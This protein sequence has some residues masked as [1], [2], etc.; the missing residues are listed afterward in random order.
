MS[1]ASK[2]K[3]WNSKP[4][5]LDEE[6]S[7]PE[8]VSYVLSFGLETSITHVLFQYRMS[9]LSYRIIPCFYFISLIAQIMSICIFIPA[10][11]EDTLNSS[12]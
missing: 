12:N 11:P 3:I 5:C 2:H 8:K 6:V 9:S 7:L 1:G 4:G 10:L